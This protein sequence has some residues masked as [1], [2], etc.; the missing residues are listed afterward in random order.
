MLPG[1]RETAVLHQVAKQMRVTALDHRK[2]SQK[3]IV[4]VYFLLPRQAEQGPVGSTHPV[5]LGQWRWLDR[6]QERA[7]LVSFT[8]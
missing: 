8:I 7:G 4:V 5:S 1:K 6:L 2:I 3:K